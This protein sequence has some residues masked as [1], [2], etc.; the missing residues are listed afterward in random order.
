MLGKI[1]VGGSDRESARCR[2]ASALAEAGITGI[3][4]NL[5]FLRTLVESDAFQIDTA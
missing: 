5:T 1:I 4:N 3:A 2:L